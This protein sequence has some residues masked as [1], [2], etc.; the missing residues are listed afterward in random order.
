MALDTV[1]PHGNLRVRLRES[2]KLRYEKML[3][4]TAA[5]CD[6]SN[7]T[8]VKTDT[9]KPS[10]S[11]AFYFKMVSRRGLEPLLLP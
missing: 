4:A 3:I 5:L 10:I 8:Q 6:E 11:W 1:L 9:K 7:N 2:R